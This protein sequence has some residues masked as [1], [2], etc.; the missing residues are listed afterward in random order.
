MD[1]N[2]IIDINEYREKAKQSL[3]HNFQKP[4]MTRVEYMQKLA[5]ERSFSNRA[6]KFITREKSLAENKTQKLV[7]S[8][9]ELAQKIKSV[10]KS[11]PNLQKAT[12]VLEKTHDKTKSF[13]KTA[14]HMANS[15]IVSIKKKT[16]NK[17]LFQLLREK[18]SSVTHK[19]KADIVKSINE[20]PNKISE[21][22]NTARLNLAK[23]QAEKAQKHIYTAKSQTLALGKPNM[24]GLQLIRDKKNPEG[25]RFQ[26]TKNISI[27]TGKTYKNGKPIMMKLKEGDTT[28]LII[29]K[30][31]KN[32]QALARYSHGNKFIKL[33]L[34]K[35]STIVMDKSLK[36]PNIFDKPMNIIKNSQ[37]TLKN[38]AQLDS[39]DVFK[40]AHNVEL[41]GKTNNLKVIDSRNVT[42]DGDATNSKIIDSYNVNTK[43]G[44]E[45]VDCVASSFKNANKQD[46]KN[47]KFNTSE[48]SLDKDNNPFKINDCNIKNARV[49]NCDVQNTNVN[50]GQYIDSGLSDSN[51]NA[52]DASKIIDS[53]IAKTFVTN[54]TPTSGAFNTRGTTMNGNTISINDDKVQQYTNVNLEHTMTNGN[55]DIEQSDIRANKEN[56]N[57]L[58]NVKTQ[59]FLS[60]TK[61]H[62]LIMTEMA[63]SSDGR[64]EVND[65]NVP[66]EL[67]TNTNSAGYKFVKDNTGK[68]LDDAKTVKGKIKP[69]RQVQIIGHHMRKEDKVR[70]TSVSQEFNF[71]PA[72]KQKHREA[73]A[74]L[75]VDI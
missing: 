35:N 11:N 23:Q 22:V 41:G 60:T 42:I 49:S 38:D 43:G 28:G 10:I 54:D 17:S 8:G 20:A 71:A 31:R 61:D 70:Q 56:P 51:I 74:D 57:F 36:D 9:S 63:M 21:K 12:N 53:S 25:Y 13:Y 67:T 30:G 2:K 16:K 33:P 39:S 58:R 72:Q 7:D 55:I 18:A 48:I 5:K 29:P 34:D 52:T 15:K 32:M 62:P 24:Q 68:E 3:N 75:G 66:K 40:N 1:N 47:A 73:T 50:H 64:L 65:E 19:V 69:S 14:K 4:T 46:V 44:F 59:N 27:N 6:K 37:I 45:N 26:A